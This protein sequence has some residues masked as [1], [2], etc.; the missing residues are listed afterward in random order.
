MN[1]EKIWKNEG[2]KKTGYVV[3]PSTSKNIV[4]ADRIRKEKP[5]SQIVA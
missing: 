5:G 2:E 1:R 3:K 4:A